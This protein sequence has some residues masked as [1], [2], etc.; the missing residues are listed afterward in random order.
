MQ[1]DILKS[2]ERMNFPFPWETNARGHII[3]TPVNYDHGNRVIRLGRML[4]I[5]EP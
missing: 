5:I 4:A 1:L 2:V 3:M